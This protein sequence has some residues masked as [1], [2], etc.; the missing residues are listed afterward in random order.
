MTQGSPKTEL[1]GVLAQLYY[2]D[3]DMDEVVSYRARLS[4]SLIAWDNRAHQT[5]RSVLTISPRTRVRSRCCWML[6]ARKKWP[7]SLFVL[8][9]KR[10]AGPKRPQLA[11]N[12]A[13]PAPRC[14]S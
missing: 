9:S 13:N 6:S 2:R 1:I 8:P 5:W 14:N 11:T 7:T 4:L 10:M 12:P 3:A